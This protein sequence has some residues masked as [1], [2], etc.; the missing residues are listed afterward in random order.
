MSQLSNVLTDRPADQA[1]VLEAAPITRT[2]L[3]NMSAFKTDAKIPAHWAALVVPTQ[4]AQLKTRQ[5]RASAHQDLPEF[6]LP[7]KAVSGYQN[8]V[9]RLKHAPM[10]KSVTEATACPHVPYTPTVPEENS[11][12]LGSA[13]RFAT[14][15]RTVFKERSV[16]TNSASLDV[17]WTT[18][19]RME[20][21]A[22]KDNVRAP[23]DSSRHPRDVL[24]LTNAAMLLFQSAQPPCSVPTSLEVSN[25]DVQWAWLVTPPLVVL[26]Q[27]SAPLMLNVLISMPALLIHSQLTV[28]VKILATLP[29]ALKEPPANPSSTNLSAPAQLSTEE[30]QLIPTLVVTRLNVRP[31][32]SVLEIWLVMLRTCNA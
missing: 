29:S 18:I 11:A 15:T 1:F 12:T 23:R 7:E 26:N 8:F 16:S 2:V 24:I 21:Y 10:V 30:T 22:N 20:N 4:F 3:D 19:A 17:M 9:D 5:K 13:S 14:Q 31:M 25:A 6:Q 28:G 32:M 27:M